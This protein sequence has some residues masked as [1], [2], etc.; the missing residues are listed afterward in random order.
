MFTVLG[1]SGFIGSN[2][3]KK[4][5]SSGLQVYSPRRGESLDNKDLGHVIYCI[6]MTADFRT[7]PF[8]TV[9]AHVC[10]L[11]SILQN[12]QF[13]SLTYLSSTRLYL[14]NH[15]SEN[16]ILEDENISLN[17]TDPFDIFAA[18]KITGELLALNSGRKN[19]KIVRLSN[20]FGADLFSENFITSVIKEALLNKEVNIFT[21]EDS[22]KDYISIDDVCLAIEKLAVIPK[23]GIYNLSYGSN[24]SNK[25]ILEEIERITGAKVVYSPVAKKIVFREISNLKLGNEIGIYPQKNIINSLNEIINFFKN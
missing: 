21:T 7:K 23:S 24:T 25:S 18:S 1:G 19:I 6:G 10:L 17:S 13:E 14:K 4:L 12:C 8:Q 16:K 2:L 11:S 5:I 20:V 15:D 3:T 9:E 22:A